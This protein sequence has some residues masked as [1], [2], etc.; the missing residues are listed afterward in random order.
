MWPKSRRRSRS[1]MR[2]D[3]V[4]G[5]PALSSQPLSLNPAVVI[6]ERVAFPS[7]DRVPQP[8][9]IGILGKIAAVGEHRAMR[10]VGRLVQHDDQRRSLDDPRQI[11][12]IVEGHADRKASRQRAVFPGIPH[13]LQEERL[14]PGLNVLGLEILRDVEAVDQDRRLSR[15]RTG[16][17]CRPVCGARA[18]TDWVCRQADAGF[19]GSDSRATARWRGSSEA[20]PQPRWM[21][22]GTDGRNSCDPSFA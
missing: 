13:A 1:V 22:H 10:A 21:P 3:S 6:D 2:S 8:C 14:G 16:P 17:A 7:P 4:C 20:A 9:R 15:C 19:R 11:E 12:E 18:R 5:C